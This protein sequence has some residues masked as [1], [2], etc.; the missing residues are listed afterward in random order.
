[1]SDEP[2]TA[3]DERHEDARP[4]D[5]D[6]QPSPIGRRLA[7]AAAVVVTVFGLAL[8]ALTVLTNTDYG[9]EKVR[10]LAETALQD[11]A[12]RGVVRIGKVTGNL[13]T[14]FTISNFS[15]RDSTGAPF[16]VAD[17]VSTNYGILPIVRK[18]LELT[19][20]R[21]VHPLIVLD[22][23]DDKKWNFKNIF[24]TGRPKT[25]RDTTKRRLGD[26][27]EFHDVTIVGG[28]L[29]VRGLWHPSEKYTTQTSR[30]SAVRRALN[31]E[32][33]LNVVEIAPGR[34]RKVSDFH[35]IDAEF[36]YFR[37][38]RP[39]THVRRLEIARI[40]MV[41]EPFR[42]PAAVVREATGAIEFTTDSA[43]W[44]GVKARMSGSTIATE[45]WYGIDENDLRLDARADPF[46]FADAQWVYPRAPARGHGTVDL[47][48]RWN[49]DTSIYVA[50][51]TDVR[52]DSAHI[53]GDL[54][55]T[56]TDTVMFHD[57]D[58]RFSDVDTRLIEQ[59]FPGARSPRQGTLLG[60][61]KLDGGAHAMRVD[62]DVTFDDRRAGRNHVL[63]NGLMGID[64]GVYARN[65]KVTLAPVRVDLARAYMPNLPIAGLVTGTLTL[66]GATKTR[67]LAEGALRHDDRGI[68]SRIDG[69][70]SVSLAGAKHLDVDVRLAPLAL[71]EVGRFAPAAGLR[72]EASGPLRLTGALGALRVDADLRMPAGGGLGVRGTMDLAS[73]QK[74]YDLEARMRLFDANAVSTKAPRTSL[75]AVTFVRGRGFDPATM[76]A[77]IGADLAASRVDTVAIDTAHVRLAIAG[78]VARVDTFLVRGAGTRA[79]VN[80]AIG[81]VADRSGE[82]AYTVQVDS[83]AT[84]R[85][86]LPP[87]DT[88]LV[89]P[90]PLQSAQRL[91]AARRDSAAR[92]AATEVE[93]A[94]VGGAR[95]G[96]IRVD[97]ATA[98]RRDSLAGSVR[99]AGTIRGSIRRFDLRGRVGATNVV[100]QG[101]TIR[102]ARGEYAWLGAPASNASLALALS[103][104]TVTAVGFSL[105]SLNARMSYRSPSG[106]LALAIHQ[107]QG[108]EYSVGS[109]FT[110]HTDHKELHLREAALRFDTTR[111]VAAHPA[112]IR[113]GVGGVEVQRLEL[114]HDDAGDVPGRIFVDGRLPTEGAANLTVAVDNFQI[115]DILSLLQSDIRAR[116]LVTT[117]MRV[118]GTLADPR[119]RGALGMVQS[120][121]G[122]APLP[123]T[124]ATVDYAAR[125]LVSHVEATRQGGRPVAMADARVPIDLS[126]TAQGSR[127]LDRPLI[128]DVNADSVPLEIIPELTDLVTG[129][130][131]RAA[132]ALRVRGTPR[133]PVLA[134]GFTLVGGAVKVVPTGTSLRDVVAAIRMAGDSVIIDSIAGYSGGRMVV[135]G[136]LGIAKPTKPSFDLYFVAENARVL[137]SDRGTARVDA[138]LTMQGPFDSVYISGRVGV[139]SGVLYAPEPSGK[140]V[141]AA[142]DPALFAVADT[143]LPTERDLVP[144]ESELVRNLRIDVTMDVARDVWVRTKDANVEVFTPPGEDLVVQV[145]RRRQKLTL[146]GSLSTDR[147]EYEVFS[148]RF[149][150]RQGTAT[151]IG[152]EGLN[153][154]LQA[155]AEYEVRVPS[156]STTNIRVLIGG[157]LEN[158]TLALESDAQPPI[159]QSDLLSLL[160]FGRE[161][162]SLLQFQG[163]TLG[164]SGGTGN[165]AGAGAALVGQ[166]LSAVALGVFVDEFEGEARRSFG[167]DVFNIT[168]ADLYTEVTRGGQ[169][170]GFL[171]GTEFEAGKYTDPNTFVSIEARPSIFASNPADRAV[172]GFR[173]QRR[174]PKG[175]RFDASFEPR[176]LLTEPSLD[177]TQIA[178]PTG[179]FGIVFAREWRF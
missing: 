9:R 25:Q 39:D 126:N 14:G 118:E 178:K 4:S 162:S 17:S 3:T 100:A 94:A 136:G 51:N 147:G 146:L 132:G 71:A 116:G 30:D 33:R 8:I 93:R 69:R 114:R 54:A 113:W 56:V 62:A 170:S 12:K 36:P 133:R 140:D 60:R 55:V 112:A 28:R 47:S 169:V 63:A 21:L 102:R 111:W 157:T 87:S 160:A 128:V 115:G 149:Q 72:G 134:G 165:L 41:A 68:V 172:P 76:R 78:G 145:D 144:S 154:L 120:T 101:S 92:A 127:L 158:L 89:R 15:I 64:G 29:L 137:D 40:A 156:R 175:F 119:I 34:Y 130:R 59:V 163:S 73:A 159:S 88:S 95:Q 37:L 122:E 82:L 106:T 138:G 164:G 105:D 174:T 1:M 142:G 6:P 2:R 45:G 123:D 85:R 65:L 176:Y 103:A 48:V 168:P 79:V 70:G 131:G 84:L 96:P 18:R 167:A 129:V 177:Q 52:I 7:L 161:T 35:D 27:I 155:T 148:K 66:N 46:V 74:G 61:V 83:L 22:Q 24:T 49:G 50:R 150:I 53:A 75:T 97:T 58:V 171:K 98:V 152:T 57:T 143:T 117:Q 42:P 139:R 13:L 43:W 10:Q 109:D 20:V 141:I 81:L 110:L 16:L 32:N 5:S 179:V 104:D 44:R 90:R 108:T 166:R 91:A 86:Y 19:D 135:R 38:K 173:I 11:A 124:R 121:Y 31:G 67:L 125:L 151:F 153:P 80:G 26:W 107:M 99:L 77:A 23:G